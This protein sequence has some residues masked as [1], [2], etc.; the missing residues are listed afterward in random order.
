MMTKDQIMR[1]SNSTPVD[2]DSPPRTAQAG[3]DGEGRVHDWLLAATARDPGAMALQD[4]SGAWTYQQLADAGTRFA[5]W[6][7][8]E[9][10]RAGDRVMLRLRNRREVAALVYATSMLGASA[11]LVDRRLRPFL[12]EGVVAD[13]APTLILLEADDADGRACTAERAVAWIE[14]ATAAA[15]RLAPGPV[16]P[17]SAGPD[18]PCLMFYTSG[19]VAAPKAVVCGHRAVRFAAYA[20]AERLGYRAADRVFVALP[21]SFDYGLYQIFLAAIVGAAVV[22]RDADRTTVRLLDDIRATEATVV[23]VVPSLASGLI[24]LSERDPAPT[25][26]RLLTNTG[27]AMEPPLAAR[28][29]AAFPGAA[30]SLMYGITECK[31]V[32]V[33]YPDEDLSRP[34]SVGRPLTGTEVAIVDESGAV[35]PPGEVG[36]IV[37]SGPHV[38]A[39]YWRAPELTQSRFRNA[40]VG[41]CATLHTGDRGRLDADG[42]LYFCGRSDDLV[43]RHGFRI[44]LLEVEAAAMTVPGVAAAAA[45]FQPESGQL[46]VLV[47]GAVT[48]D[49]AVLSELV[50]KLDRARAPDL[51]RVVDALP[52]TANGKVDRAR[53]PGLVGW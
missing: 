22:L 35:L 4:A 18:T 24:A 12:L 50:S 19:S 36:E 40:S 38:M 31:R 15:D 7:Y 47:S 5:R 34:G 46:A 33:M 1:A 9:G 25:R 39:G 8:R 41:H 6:L 26:V 43:K 53:L 49:A 16:E 44:S 32:S 14:A 11:V 51:C 42:Y 27:A 21:L 30:L 28:L 37:V 23:P 29:R 2:S 13:C 17:A 48:S 52:Y 10:V 20:I 3:S 45:V